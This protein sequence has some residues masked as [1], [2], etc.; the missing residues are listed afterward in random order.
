MGKKPAYPNHVGTINGTIRMGHG[1][2]LHCD[3][4]ECLHRA[5]IDLEAIAKR[6]GV[7]LSVAEFVNLSVRSECGASWE[8]DGLDVNGSV[9]R[10]KQGRAPQGLW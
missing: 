5:R 9:F 10:K 7:E 3:N 4:R 2:W 8:F 6:Y 1:L